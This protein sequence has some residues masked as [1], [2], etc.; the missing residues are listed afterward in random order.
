MVNTK[1]KSYLIGGVVLVVLVALV[2]GIVQFLVNREKPQKKERKIQAITMVKPPPPPPPPPKVEKPP[3]PEPEQKIE[4]QAA[5]EPEE[6]P[7]VANEPPAGDLGLDAEG[8]AGSD[9]FGLAARKG[10][11]GLF[12]GGGGSP[13]AW[14]GNLIKN[15]IQDLISGNEDL[16]AKDYSIVIKIWLENDGS[17]KRFELANSSND[18]DIDNLLK[19]IIGSYNK[20]SQPPPPGMEQPVKFQITSKT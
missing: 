7:D 3:E 12:G 1:L 11:K 18:A 6:V 20:V 17:V 13:Y 14:F 2:T 5:P 9:G 19:K 15:D 4:E 8:S 10:G 16:R